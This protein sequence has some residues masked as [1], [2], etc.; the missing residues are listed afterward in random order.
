MPTTHKREHKV[1]GQWSTVQQCN[2]HSVHLD[3]THLH[4]RNQ[5]TCVCTYVRH[6]EQRTSFGAPKVVN[7]LAINRVQRRSTHA[8]HRVFHQRPFHS[9][10]RAA[11]TT[12]PTNA[13]PLTRSLTRAHTSGS[14][15]FH[16]LISGANCS[17]RNACLAMNGSLSNSLESPSDQF[18]PES[19]H[20]T[21]TWASSRYTQN[22]KKA[23]KI[24]SNFYGYL[25]NSIE[26]GRIWKKK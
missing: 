20:S 25:R 7:A 11:Y 26:K 3:S 16:Q 2:E 10:N 5:H 14:G 17:T 8:P 15:S 12:P 6:Q 23:G 13:V 21:H 22:Q 4:A 18:A 19:T 1:Y 24:K 9:N